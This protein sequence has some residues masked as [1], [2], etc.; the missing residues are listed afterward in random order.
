MGEYAD[1]ILNG[2]FCQASGEYLGKGVGYPRTAHH[3]QR[4]FSK[5]EKQVSRCRIK[6]MYA[7]GF[8]VVYKLDPI[9]KIVAENFE[10]EPEEVLFK[11]VSLDPELLFSFQKAKL[12][13][14]EIKYTIAIPTRPKATNAKRQKKINYQ[15]SKERF[16]Q[17]FDIVEEWNA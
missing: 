16:N 17:L 15:L 5:K 3:V 6:K 1:A 8:K 4:D 2:E 9:V 10:A 12:K 13:T 14:G 7:Q 11:S